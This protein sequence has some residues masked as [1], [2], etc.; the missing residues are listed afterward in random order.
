MSGRN[1][2]LAVPKEEVAVQ[3]AAPINDTQMIALMACNLAGTPKERAE[4]A[5]EIFVE[6]VIQA[7]TMKQKLQ[8]RS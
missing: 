2:I 1:G 7:R 3:M 4:L 5:V 8:A 6:S